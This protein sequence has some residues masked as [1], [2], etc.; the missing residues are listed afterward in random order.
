MIKY[1]FKSLRAGSLQE[2]DEYR[3][4]AWVYVEA[5]TEEELESLV[6]RFKIYPGHIEDSLDEYDMP[7]LER[8]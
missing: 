2:L 7:R 4:G 5:P 8:E 1:F 6:P 3:R